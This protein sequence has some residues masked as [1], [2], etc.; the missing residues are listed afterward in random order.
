[1]RMSKVA[2]ITGV[3][4]GVGRALAK[5][6]YEDGYNLGMITRSE[7]DLTSLVNELGASSARVIF[8]AGDAAD[9]HLA[10]EIVQEVLKQFGQVD[11]LI[12]NAGMGK[13]GPLD[14]LTVA[15]YDDMMNS[16]MRSTFL[17]TYYVVPHLKERRQGNI[18]NIASVAGIKGLP[19]ESIYC[20]TKFAQVGFGQALDQELRPFG[21][22]VTNVCPGGIHT[23]FAIGTGRTEG[24]PRMNEFLDAEDIVK[25]VRFVLDQNPKSR[26]MEILMRPMY[27]A[28]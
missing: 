27:E 5:A 23:H 19:Q 28:H 6:L 9:E 21:I 18:I 24:D 16:N 7:S 15:D 12:N 10:Q 2:V 14:E 11:V 13:Y 3:G 20:A 4:K 17:Y 25:A 22:K 1:M 8:R 26:I